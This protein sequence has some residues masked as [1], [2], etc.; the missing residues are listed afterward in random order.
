[1]IGQCFLVFSAAASGRG[2][3]QRPNLLSLSSITGIV[4]KRDDIM[5][6]SLYFPCMYVYRT[7]YFTKDSVPD[8]AL[9]QV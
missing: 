6:T 9:A 2:Q 8:W 1:M 7:D 3:L 5:V 4:G